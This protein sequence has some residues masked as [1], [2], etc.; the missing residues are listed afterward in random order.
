LDTTSLDVADGWERKVVMMGSGLTT[1]SIAGKCPQIMASLIAH[2]L[3]DSILPEI[4][5][6]RSRAKRQWEWIQSLATLG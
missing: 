3:L 1:H 4:H 6:T 5:R 2:F